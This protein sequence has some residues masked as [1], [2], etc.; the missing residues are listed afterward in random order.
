MGYVYI[1]SNPLFPGIYKVGMTVRSVPERIREL[2]ST[3]VPAKFEA[4]A[5]YQVKHPRR[6]ERKAH[7][8]LNTYRVSG[9]REFFDVDVRHIEECLLTS[10]RI[11]GDEV[12]TDSRA[13][14]MTDSEAKA[15]RNQL[16]KQASER[17]ENQGKEQRDREVK[18]RVREQQYMELISSSKYK[19][20]VSLRSDWSTVR[21]LGILPVL[22][23][24]LRLRKI[25][26]FIKE[27]LS[28]CGRNPSA[29]TKTSTRPDGG[30]SR[31]AF[32]ALLLP[33]LWG[34][35]FGISAQME[36]TDK[37]AA[38]ESYCV[39]ERFPKGGEVSRKEPKCAWGKSGNRYL[40]W[41]NTQVSISTEI[42]P[43]VS[44]EKLPVERV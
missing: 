35:F 8:L 43:G 16:I 41:Q 36:F 10:I 38:L 24:G 6:V 21:W 3:G 17:K 29:H 37:Y 11:T 12:G 26:P 32:L 27:K 30:P 18:V 1:L 22:A 42:F 33:M 7:E 40:A 15:Y 23:I 19:E 4:V 9:D 5:Y 20:W 39:L 44:A 2:A 28:E 13:T 14:G 31:F 34:G 25:D